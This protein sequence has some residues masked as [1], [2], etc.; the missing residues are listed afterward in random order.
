MHLTALEEAGVIPGKRSDTR[1]KPL[2]LLTN[3]HDRLRPNGLSFPLVM[4][5][6][7]NR[8]KLFPFH[9]RSGCFSSE[10]AVRRFQK[11]NG[12]LDP[13]AV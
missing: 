5:V 7:Y 4:A 13:E 11:R 9:F 8:Y 12:H 10:T 2:L 3:G 1:I 6:T